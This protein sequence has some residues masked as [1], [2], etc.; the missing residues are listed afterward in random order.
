MRFA[1]LAFIF[2]QT[3]ACH[4]DISYKNRCLGEN[5][6]ND[7]ST[8]LEGVC[9]PRV[10]DASPE[11]SA[12]PES[13]PGDEPPEDGSDGLAPAPADAG[14]STADGRSD[15]IPPDAEG[16]DSNLGVMPVAS[17]CFGVGCD[18]RWPIQ[19]AASLGTRGTEA[20]AIWSQL[21]QPGRWR[22]LGFSDVTG[23][24]KA[25]LIAI[26]RPGGDGD[27]VPLWIA[28][29]D[30]SRFA[31]P[32][33]AGEAACRRPEDCRLGDVDG[34]GRADVIQVRAPATAP[35][36]HAT[37]LVSREN[38]S[39]LA[40]LTAVPDECTRAEL[41]EAADVNA[42]GL[43][44]L[45]AFTRGTAGVTPGAGSVVVSLFEKGFGFRRSEGWHDGFCFGQQPCRVFDVDGD[46]RSDLVAFSR[47][48]QSAPEGGLVLLALSSGTSFGPPQR[49]SESF[50]APDETCATGDVDGDGNVDIVAFSRDDPGPVWLLRSLGRQA[51]AP[52]LWSQ[53]FCG[54]HHQCYLAD[55]NGDGKADPVIVS[56]EPE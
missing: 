4:L 5:D 34:D 55:V 11:V 49:W 40:R 3:G 39:A 19:V 27:A 43:A 45:V 26:E 14:S 20:P 16:S 12:G 42:D 56:V 41:C 33:L 29:S 9:R 54:R 1:A 30:G 10:L 28:A 18:G 17:S 38:G 47:N 7:D 23:D 36:E 32:Y 50:C 53:A 2:L 31:P 24:G 8:C 13:G 6:C 21:D 44:D 35:P 37:V 51:D 22:V 46:H 15:L 52:R 48:E 25:D